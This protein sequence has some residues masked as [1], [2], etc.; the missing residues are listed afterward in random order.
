MAVTTND[1][2]FWD[3]V[4]HEFKVKRHG[5]W[6]L[7]A[8]LLRLGILVVLLSAAYVLFY[9]ILSPPSGYFISRR[10]MAVHPMFWVL[11]GT[12]FIIVGSFLRFRAIGPIVDK[13][14]QHGME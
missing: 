1:R 9:Y 11:V 7:S 10:E 12:I 4:E 8:W 2:K 5:M 3:R 14:K 13:F 6:L